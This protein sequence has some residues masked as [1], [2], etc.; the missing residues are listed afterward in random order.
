LTKIQRE[1]SPKT[2]VGLWHAHCLIAAALIAC[3]RRPASRTKPRD[4]EKVTIGRWET[5]RRWSQLC[6]EAFRETALAAEPDSMIDVPLAVRVRRLSEFT[7]ILSMLVLGIALKRFVEGAPIAATIEASAVCLMLVLRLF[8]LRRPTL[9]KFHFASVALLWL[10]TW[11]IV[12]TALVLGQMQSP[13]LL[14]ISLVPLA[15]GYYTRARGALVWGLVACASVAFVGLTQLIVPIAPEVPQTHTDALVT[16]LVVLLITTGF[17]YTAQRGSERH[18]RELQKREDRI[19]WQAAELVVARDAALEASR[20]KSAFLANTSHE[21]RTPMNVIIGMTDM[22]LETDL[23]PTARDWLQRVRSAS[24]A[25]L[26]II[27]DLLDLSKIEAGKMALEV[28]LLDLRATVGEVVKLLTPSATAKGLA[29]VCRLDP[30]V[31]ACVCGD[32]GR[33]GQVLTNL[34]G[35]AIKF[36]DR[37]EVTLEVRL[38]HATASHAEI[39][40]AVRD[41]GIGIPPDRQAAVFESFTQ[42]DGSMTRKFGGTGLGLTISRQLVQLMGGELRLES[43]VGKGSTFFFTLGLD[44]ALA[45]A[46]APPRQ[47]PVAELSA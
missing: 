34:L 39:L 37:G 8:A 11:I 7:L 17:S 1:F 3:A 46:T 25:L 41:T 4:D 15:G 43:A 21:I 44:L 35:N 36:A 10:G 30:A 13:S 24:L 6:S 47:A 28:G 5:V 9:P 29:L 27:N 45:A 31:P 42:A 33:L 22:A 26:G 19:R 32:G 12:G 38:V 20:V 40:F 18:L 23:E 16:L 14:Y 2:V